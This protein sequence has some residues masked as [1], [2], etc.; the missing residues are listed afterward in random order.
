MVAV[1]QFS[2]TRSRIRP[3]SSVSLSRRTTDWGWPR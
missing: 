1:Y 3:A 2:Q